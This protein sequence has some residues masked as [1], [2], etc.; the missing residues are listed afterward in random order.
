MKIFFCH[1]S[2]DKS[3]VRELINL[4][5]KTLQSWLDEDKLYVGQNLRQ[6]LQSAIES[7]HFVVAILSR[8]S[9]KSDWVKYELKV[10]LEKES[11]TNRVAILPIVIDPIQELLPDF[12]RGRHYLY[13][14]DRS[15]DQVK[16]VA[17][18]LCKG[19]ANW[20][21]E[22]DPLASL[23]KEQSYVLKAAAIG[24]GQNAAAVSLRLPEL[25]LKKIQAIYFDT[26]GV[27][28]KSGDTEFKKDLPSSWLV[29]CINTSAHE[30]RTFIPKH[31]PKP[32][33]REAQADAWLTVEQYRQLVDQCFFIGYYGM[34]L[35]RPVANIN[36]DD[37]KEYDAKKICKVF[38]KMIAKL[39]AKDTSSLSK[40]DEEIWNLGLKWIA[41][42]Y[43]ALVEKGILSESE[44]IE[45]TLI[46]A[47][48]TGFTFSRAVE[49]IASK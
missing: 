17:E 9:I 36:V 11:A 18:K 48:F 24:E 5:P 13:L 43:K 15:R 10:A 23:L 30:L 31:M 41:I 28:E 35:R 49:Q 26:C 32:V 6:T 4:L 2:E 21:I 1:S 46:K 33:A 45:T 27:I 34:S 25:M 42:I 8:T 39:H 38:D 22:A 3:F 7:S 44:H 47:M 12:I 14:H 40:I 37:N 16:I 29:Q 20:M 19:I